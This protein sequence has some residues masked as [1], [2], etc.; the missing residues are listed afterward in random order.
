M[1]IIKKIGIQNFRCIKNFVWCPS[2]GINCLV[3]HGDSGKSTI[4]DAI[5]LC[6]T[7]RRN[8][9]FSDMD[10]YNLDITQPIQ[11]TVVIGDLPPECLNFEK[12]GIYLRGFNHEKSSISDEPQ[13]GEE[14]VLS[15]R[16]T[17]RDDLEPE[18]SLVTRST[19]VEGNTRSL[20]WQDKLL[21][22]PLR[23]G[24]LN[25]YHLGWKNGSILNQLSNER[26]DTS[27]LVVSLSREARKIFGS[28]GDELLCD[29]LEIVTNTAKELG[30][31]IG[32]QAHAMLDIGAVSYGDGVLS[33]HDASNISMRN[34]GT[35]SSR[36]L[37]AGL[38]KKVS[39]KSAILLFDEFEFGLE[40]HRI[41]RLLG[42]LGA[43]EK[44]PQQQVF[45][46]THSPVV[47]RELSGSQLSIFRKADNEHTVK[48]I[49][50]DD[51][52][53]GTIRKYPDALL[54]QN[55]I[56]C[57]GASEVGFIRG[58]D[59]Y[60]RG[61]DEHYVPI[62]ANGVA[63]VDGGG[64]RE[65]CK[66]ALNFHQLGYN[67]LIF[68]DDDEKPKP[69]DEALIAEAN[70]E[71]I[72]WHNDNAIEDALFASLPCSA[73]L[74]ILKYASG[75]YE[76]QTVCDQFKS[77][78]N[79]LFNL[80]EIVRDIENKLTDDVRRF[81]GLAAKSKKNSW[82]KTQ[83]KMEHIAFSVVGCNIDNADTEFSNV[84]NGI[85]DWIKRHGNH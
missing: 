37:L 30:V 15:L 36:L 17:V 53:Q 11:I 67:V 14:T 82:F 7:S 33:L 72:K 48:S 29:A 45:M 55:V 35:G 18:W 59:D 20:A 65:L 40:P 19:E 50:A 5:E 34:L 25:N 32:D 39:K 69:E 9:H 68:R 22:S 46:T 21:L 77:A 75:I 47:L 56:I 8:V 70:I 64:I 74:E 78:S 27:S 61:Q 28:R 1:P 63:L 44:T 49:A 58:L 24:T 81:L 80:E 79:G 3:G 62:L 83:T 6:L 4:L 60:F 31:S 26:P 51:A 42:Y 57:E 52:I 2:S 85:F 73:I 66:R 13:K 76:E 38:H 16:L 12:Y 10:F 84:V 41:I 43:K 23:I 71:V 54:A